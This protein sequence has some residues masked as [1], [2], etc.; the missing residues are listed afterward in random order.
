[1]TSK[2]RRGEGSDPVSETSNKEGVPFALSLSHPLSLSRARSLA[3]C[4]SLSSFTQGGVL[5]AIQARHNRMKGKT[6]SFSRS[7]IFFL[8]LSLAPF[9]SLSLSLSPFLSRLLAVP[10]SLRLH[11]GGAGSQRS[12]LGGA[13]LRTAP[14]S[15]HPPLSRKMY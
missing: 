14:C 7:L 12:S 1:M 10:S 5:T 15:A 9:L 8:S 13:S 11:K 4:C 6:L 3:R 2:K